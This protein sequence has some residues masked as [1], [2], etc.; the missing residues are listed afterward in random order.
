VLA[1]HQPDTVRIKKLIAF[2]VEIDPVV[3]T[4]IDVSEDLPAPPN[5]QYGPRTFRTVILDTHQLK[6]PS[7]L[8]GNIIHA[9]NG[10]SNI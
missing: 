9:A 4:F 7:F 1:A 6:T 3:G 10:I 2:P 5:H 8:A